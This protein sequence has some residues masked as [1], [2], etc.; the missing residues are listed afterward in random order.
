MTPTIVER[1]EFE[2]LLRPVL[3]FAFRYAVRLAG[4]RDSGMDLVQDASVAAYRAFH[5]F[6]RGSNFKAWYLRILTNRFYQAH[7]ERSRAPLVEMEEAPE[8]YLYRQARRLGVPMAGDPSAFV[9]AKTDGD[10]ICDALDRLSDDYRAVAALHFSGELTYE[11]CAQALDIP[12]GTVRSRLHRARRQL[13]VALWQIAE[14]RGYAPS[15]R[16]L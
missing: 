5:Q 13:Q 6:A 11:E 14:E 2:A 4:E 10:A 1:E 7:R 3:P 15:E 16:T 8:L 12:I 9:L